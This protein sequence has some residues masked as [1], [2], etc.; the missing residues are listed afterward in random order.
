M[1]GLVEGKWGAFV[2]LTTI[3]NKLNKKKMKAPSRQGKDAKA[4]TGQFYGWG[5]WVRTTM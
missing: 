4:S 2:L 5:R 3:K 1:K